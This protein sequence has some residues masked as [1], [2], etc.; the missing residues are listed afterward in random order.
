MELFTGSKMKQKMGEE[1]EKI[2]S[3]IISIGVQ[4][5]IQLL[6]PVILGVSVQKKLNN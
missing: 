6:Y 3:Q 1:I 4:F 5:N 2:L